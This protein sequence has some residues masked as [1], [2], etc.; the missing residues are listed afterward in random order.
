LDPVDYATQLQD[1]HNRLERFG[2]E[3]VEISVAASFNLSY[4]RLAPEAA[5]V[6]RLLAVFPATFDA[7]A[8]E[9]VCAD[10]EHL[11]L[12]DLVRRNL[13]LYDQSTKRYRL[14]DLAR[15]FADAKLNA[16]ER[17]VG[18]KRFAMH[19]KDVLEASNNL[20]LEGGES[21]LRGLAF[22]D[23]EWA[24]IQTGHAWVAART[25]V[26][27][28]EV[29]QLGMT[30]PNTGVYVLDLRQHSREQIRWLEI[31]LAVAR[32]FQD[33][34]GEART[35]GN[36]GVAYGILG[37][38]QRAIQ[39]FEQILVIHR[40]LGDR[41]HEGN[42]LC[43]LGNAYAGLGQTSRA[44]NF[45]EEALRIHREIGDRRGEG[46]ALCNLGLAYIDLDETQRAIQFFQQALLIF[47]EIGDRR[48]EGAL[49]NNLG[50]AYKKLGETRLATQFYEQ[51]LIIARE[52]GDR[53]GEGDALWNISLALDQLRE[54]V[55][56]IQHAEQ[57]LTIYEQIEDPATP[58]VRAQLAAWRE[59][60]NT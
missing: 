60:T 8:E 46:N 24:N 16:K 2:T 53:R 3:G 4:E 1:E 20:Y 37:E 25:D 7:A 21:L 35:L 17:T 28:A 54:R 58:K 42:D 18:Q 40:E 48:S 50:L 56:A 10:A 29:A 12:R 57:A 52:I 31:A 39:F 59:Q 5:R 44:N 51:R 47:S 27:D 26:A 38:T 15:L 43:N 23:L 34:A 49:R 22:F 6:F 9:I 30:Y 33:R 45:Y 32:R 55:Q 36:L 14:H 19:Y 11:Q 13:V 41:K